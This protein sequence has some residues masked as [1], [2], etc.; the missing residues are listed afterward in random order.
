MV[1]G[2]ETTTEIALRYMRDG[3]DNFGVVY[4]K[5]YQS[6]D[7][8]LEDIFV[9]RVENYRVT[10]FQKTAEKNFGVPPLSTCITE[11]NGQ[12]IILVTKLFKFN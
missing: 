5:P 10:N 2:R 7:F 8:E 3:R 11:N 12:F 6:Q 1:T 4:H 9:L